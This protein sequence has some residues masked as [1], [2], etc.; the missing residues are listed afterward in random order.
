MFWWKFEI[1]QC[2]HSD[3]TL[4]DCIIYSEKNSLLNEIYSS[5]YLSLDVSCYINKETGIPIL[6]IPGGHLGY[7]QIPEVFAY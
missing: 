1:R 2:M 3:I 7:N 5:G 6:D 4:D